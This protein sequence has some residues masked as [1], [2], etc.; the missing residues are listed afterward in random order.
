MGNRLE[1]RVAAGDVA[2]RLDI[3]GHRCGVTSRSS[4]PGARPT[5]AAV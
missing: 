3:Q 2:E 4:R 5:T 1:K